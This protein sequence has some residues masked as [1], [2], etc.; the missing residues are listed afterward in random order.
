MLVFL[1]NEVFNCVRVCASD[2]L[3][4]FC[5]TQCFVAC[6]AGVSLDKVQRYINHISCIYANMDLYVR[7]GHSIG[8]RGREGVER[9]GKREGKK[10]RKRERER[11]KERERE[12]G[13]ER[14]REG[15][16]ETGLL[17]S[18]TQGQSRSPHRA[19]HNVTCTQH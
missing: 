19:N 8:K 10:E 14:E 5:H 4:A 16:R 2:I 13:R 15:E 7:H 6:F 1:L 3:F 12:R 18:A 11:E 9:E 17:I